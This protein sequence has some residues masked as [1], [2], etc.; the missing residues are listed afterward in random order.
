MQFNNS[1]NTECSQI[2]YG[3]L[4]YQNHTPYQKG[5]GDKKHN[6]VHITH[7]KL[8]EGYHRDLKGVRLGTSA[9]R[10]W[11]ISIGQYVALCTIFNIKQAIKLVTGR[12]TRDRG[13]TPDPSDLWGY[14]DHFLSYCPASIRGGH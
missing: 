11:V 8:D 14:L 2:T 7:E 13:Y 3:N 5:Q 6:T 4:C 9:L 12:D 10:P 1:H